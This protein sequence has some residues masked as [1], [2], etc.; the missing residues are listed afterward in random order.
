MSADTVT[1]LSTIG[2]S[3]DKSNLVPK[4]N[5]FINLSL[6]LHLSSTTIGALIVGTVKESGLPVSRRVFCY[7]R[8]NGSLVA[9]TTSN[10]SG[11]YQFDGLALNP[12]YYIV[13]LDENGDTVQYNAVIQDLI[14][15]TKV[16]V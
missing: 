10:A 9:T 15:A 7:L 4:G 8:E 3:S 5:G 2:F 6:P 16:M 12:D 11:E 14:R 13:S 1:L